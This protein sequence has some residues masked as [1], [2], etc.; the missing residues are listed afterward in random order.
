MCLDKSEL[1]VLATEEQGNIKFCSINFDKHSDKYPER[2]CSRCA[3]KLI[4]VNLLDMS[5]IIFD[6]CEKCGGLLLIK[7]KL[8]K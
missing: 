5:N 2:I 3:T 8:S 1:N 4:K 6:Y 7:M